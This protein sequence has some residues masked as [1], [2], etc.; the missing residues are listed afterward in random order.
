MSENELK[1]IKFLRLEIKRTEQEINAISSGNTLGAAYK[2]LLTETRKKR[3]EQKSEM[4]TMINSVDDSE[5]RLILKLKFVDLRSWN[6][7]ANIMHYDR[8]TVYKKYKKFMTT[9]KLN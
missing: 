5:M 3:Y 9:G 4:E 7:I 6:Y 8:S 1:N 2:E